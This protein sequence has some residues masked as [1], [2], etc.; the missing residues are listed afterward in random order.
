MIRKI[1]FVIVSIIGIVLI[2]IASSIIPIDRYDYR[3]RGFYHVMMRRLDS[4]KQLP[5]PVASKNF[6]VGYAKVNL[7][8]RRP[9]AIASYGTHIGKLYAGVHDSIYVR[10]IVISNGE[11]KVA[12]V[13]ADLLI[14][15]PTVTATLARELPEIGFSLNTT[16][17]NAVHSHNSIGNWGSGAVMDI[18][19]GKY[20]DT[21]VHFIADRIK[22][23]ILIASASMRPASIRVSAIPLRSPV[24]NRLDKPNGGVDSLLHIVEI[25][26]K[27]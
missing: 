2:F 15:P 23:S 6:S 1:L 9:T 10:A 11:Q 5:K 17:L 14:M 19:Y 22:E 21:L 26:K 3:T 7:T 24:R 4:L 16:Y 18:L 25:K 13:S 12:V 20:N 27:R 8:P